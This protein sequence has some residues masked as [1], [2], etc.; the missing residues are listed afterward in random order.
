MKYKEKL[1]EAKREVVKRLEMWEKQYQNGCSDP[2]WSDGCNLNLLRNHILYYKNAIKNICEQNNID[3][4]GEYF[5]PAPPEVDRN[6]FA[7]PN[8]ER[9]K[10]ILRNYSACTNIKESDRNKYFNMEQLSLF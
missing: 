9:A 8:S 10:R 3:F 4:P 2:F 7:N 5:L 1:L 6:Y